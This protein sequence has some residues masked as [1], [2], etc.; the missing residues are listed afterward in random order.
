MTQAHTDEQSSRQD[1]LGLSPAALRELLGDIVDRPYRSQQIF[2]A[3]YRHGVREFSEMTTLAKSLR[4]RLAQDFFIGVPEIA[5]VVE[6]GDGTRKLLLR[7]RDG[8]TVETVDIPTPRRRTLCI[9]SQAGCALAC[10]FCVT[11]FW[12]A[13]RNLTSGEIVGQV[14]ATLGKLPFGGESVNIV[15]MGMGEPMHNLDN[16]R[17]A[18]EIL[19]QAISWRR[20]TLST[21]GVIAGI[22]ELGT[23]ERRPNLAVSLHAPDDERRDRIMP[24]NRTHPIG[25]LFDALSRYPLERGRRITFE[26][27]LIRDFNDSEAA[28][29]HLA[30][31]IRG[32][33]G[34]INLIPLNPDPV[35]GPGMKPPKPE[36]VDRFAARL[37]HLGVTTTVRRQRGDDV[38]A[39]CGQLRAP[40]REPRGFRRSGWVA[41]GLA[42]GD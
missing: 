18:L 35:L 16:V 14:L 11:G 32:V 42:D 15:L 41:A 26:Y 3:I 38:S 29:T 39:A 19:S 25:E 8:V 10:T 22:D 7:L 1:V 40:D 21:V 30:E 36:K 17:V 27:L 2:D 23:W 28:A 9:S 6:S 5:Q 13:G 24:I 31:R 20:M 12:G 4:E 34:K 33:Q 37:R